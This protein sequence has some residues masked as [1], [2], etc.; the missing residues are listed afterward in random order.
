MTK[1]KSRFPVYSKILQ[2]YPASYRQRYEKEMLQTTADMLDDA[3]STLAKIGIWSRLALDLPLN[4]L[5]QQA[6]YAGGIMQDEMPHFVKRNGLISGVMLLP[7]FAALSANSLDK[8]INNHTL[9]N[10][11]LWRTPILGIWVIYLPTFALLLAGSTYLTYILK[12]PSKKSFINRI[13][14]IAH[15]WPVLLTGLIAL[16]IL[17]ILVFHDSFRCWVQT[18]AHLASHW[19]QTWQCSQFN[20]API[21]KIFERAFKL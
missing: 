8:L 12:N 17:F 5:K 11:W 16:G 4:V 20:K 6:V 13:L 10:S 19:N 2:L 9:F 15:S 14:D 21:T 1:L 7:F 18:P 3:P